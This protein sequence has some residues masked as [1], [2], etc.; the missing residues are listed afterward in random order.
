MASVAASQ[1]AF[2]KKEISTCCFRCS[3]CSFI[4][5]AIFIGVGAGMCSLSVNREPC[6]NSDL[7]SGTS[8]TGTNS[9]GPCGGGLADDDASFGDGLCGFYC[10]GNDVASCANQ[11]Y[12]CSDSSFTTT[13]VTA[14]TCC[15]SNTAGGLLGAGIACMVF[16][17]LVL[18]CM[19]RCY[20][21]GWRFDNN[22]NNIHT[23]PPLA[24]QD[25]LPVAV[26]AVSTAPAVPIVTVSVANPTTR[27]MARKTETTII[28]DMFIFRID[29]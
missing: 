5:G 7:C 25:S 3:S 22:S 23:V 15:T 27:K 6:C 20:C 13:C 18:L 24:S 19:A 14:P 21:Q 16:F 12:S 17:G 9:Y 29:A 28:Y 11:V 10:G 1:S 26:A 8:G 2:E 4:I